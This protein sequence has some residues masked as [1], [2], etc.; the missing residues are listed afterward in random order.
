MSNYT[1]R[2]IEIP[3]PVAVEVLSSR[4]LLELNTA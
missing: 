4:Q 1:A 2:G 3:Q